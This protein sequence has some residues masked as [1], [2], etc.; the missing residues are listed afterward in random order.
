[1]TVEFS[2]PGQIP[3]DVQIAEGSK[4]LGGTKTITGTS[5]S[6][7]VELKPGDYTFFCSV[8]GHREGGMQG[9]LTVT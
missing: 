4:E 3:H 8:P 1:V 5:Q 9:T 7:D 6:F 2:N